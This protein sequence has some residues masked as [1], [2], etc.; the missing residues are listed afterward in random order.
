M[1]S[2]AA[3]GG[4]STDGHAG[5]LRGLPG[6]A[7]TGKIDVDRRVR[8]TITAHL[9]DIRSFRLGGQ[10]EKPIAYRGPMSE[11][12]TFPIED[13]LRAAYAVAESQAAVAFVRPRGLAGKLAVGFRLRYG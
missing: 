8:C 13:A 9:I 4:H 1:E 10:S 11:G 6:A 5:G 7:E 12:P 3:G 2:Y